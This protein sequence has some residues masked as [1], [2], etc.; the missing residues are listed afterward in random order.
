MTLAT[1]RVRAAPAVTP[2][3]SFMLGQ[4][5]IGLGL[6][7]L[8]APKGVNR[9]LGLSN[10]P[11]ATQLL[12]GAREMATGVALFSDPTKAGALWAR[13]AGDIFDIAVLRSLA[14]R[15]NPKRRNAK[16]ALG[17]VLAVT[18]LDVVA[19]LRMTNVKRTCD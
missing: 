5:A 18:A 11:Q 12:F 14:T 13:V 16:L 17:V 3:V 8:L 15:H 19:A 2:Q 10:S 9:F 7:G 6:W 1:D 4:N